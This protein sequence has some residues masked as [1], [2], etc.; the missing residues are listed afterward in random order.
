MA[1]KIKY[2][3]EEVV[4]DYALKD[5]LGNIFSEQY[6][7]KSEIEANLELVGTEENLTSVEIKGTK[8]KI[9]A[10]GGSGGASANYNY[11]WGE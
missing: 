2:D 4:V 9:P 6:M 7:A 3:N 11:Y 5:G 8:Y 1:K 10:G